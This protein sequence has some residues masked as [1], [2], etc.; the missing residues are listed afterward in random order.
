MNTGIKIQN[1][2][3][4]HIRQALYTHT[5]GSIYTYGR[6]YIHIWQALY[7]HMA[8]SIY[9]YG[10]L[11]IHIRQALYTH[12]AGSIYTDHS[13]ASYDTLKNVASK[14]FFNCM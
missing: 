6:L 2:N 11:Y 10:R 1:I 7:T 4:L 13:K 5:A 8:G 3:T 14:F 12:T 9:T